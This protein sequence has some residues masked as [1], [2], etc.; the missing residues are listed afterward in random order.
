[1]EGIDDIPKRE[2][3][4]ING[5][6]SK[7][8]NNLSDRL[9]KDAKSGKATFFTNTKWISGMKSMTTVGEYKL[10]GQTKQF[11]NRR[12]L[13]QSDE[14]SELGGA[15]MAPSAI[16]EL[17]HAVGTCIVAAANA[18]AI[19]NKVKLTKIDVKLE[20]DINL[21]G[22]LNLY[23][24]TRPGLLDFRTTITIAGDADEETLKNIAMKGFELSPVTDTVRHGAAKTAKPKI[25]VLKHNS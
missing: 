4:I 19:L 25:I 16:E 15:D 2:N 13:L 14:I 10:D 22:L 5:L 1:L 3:G 11:Q 23:P 20:S 21:R 18:N 6:N 12:F 7:I 9:R 24:R 8:L 17:M